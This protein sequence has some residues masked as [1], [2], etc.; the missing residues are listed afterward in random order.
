MGGVQTHRGTVKVTVEA[1]EGALPIPCL[2]DRLPPARARRRTVT[3]AGSG[4][5][6]AACST[7]LGSSPTALSTS[8]ATVS[9]KWLSTR[10]RAAEAI[11]CGSLAS[12][13]SRVG[14]NRP[15]TCWAASGPMVSWGTSRS[16]IQRPSERSRVNRYAALCA[17]LVFEAGPNSAISLPSWLR[18]SLHGSALEPVVESRPR[19]SST[20]NGLCGERRPPCR[21]CRRAAN[22]SAPHRGRISGLGRQPSCLILTSCVAWTAPVDWIVEATHKAVPR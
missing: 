12:I 9:G 18:A 11:S 14:S 16:R 1:T 2:D 19:A 21:C 4:S 5:V 22:G 20:S 7:V 17:R 3:P 13:A 6:A 10:A 8:G 15:V